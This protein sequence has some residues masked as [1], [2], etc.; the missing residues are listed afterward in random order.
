[1]ETKAIKNRGVIITVLLTALVL[2]CTFWITA[3]LIDVYKIAVVGAIFEILWLPMLA[4]TFGAPVAAL[5]FW[6][7]ERFRI[8]SVFLY[9]LLLSAVSVYFIV[10]QD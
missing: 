2:S 5:I 7:K 9:L 8:S 1:M 3:A 6:Y 4:L 10:T